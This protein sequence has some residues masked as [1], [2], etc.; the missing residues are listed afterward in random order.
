M[1]KRSNPPPAITLDSE[2]LAPLVDLLDRIPGGWRPSERTVT[3]WLNPPAG[4]PGLPHLR[5]GKVVLTTPA[6]LN[7]FFSERSKKKRR[8]VARAASKR[9][10]SNQ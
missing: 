5:A 7:W 3:S 8:A 2:G 10:R 9:I 6:A 4:S 1:R